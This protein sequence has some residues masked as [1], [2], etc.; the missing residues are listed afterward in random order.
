MTLTAPGV[1]VHVDKRT[2]KVCL[3]TKPGGVNLP[4]WHAEKGL[5]FTHFVRDLRRLMGDY[6]DVQYFR[7]VEAQERHA[8]H[9]HLLVRCRG[10]L[11]AKKEAI[12]RLAIK[13]GFGHS[14]DLRWA[15]P[16]DAGY[17]A[18]YVSVSCD[19]KAEVPWLDKA[20]GE[21]VRPRFR[22]WTATRRWGLTRRKLKEQQVEWV[23]AQASKRSAVE[24]ARQG[25]DGA[26][27]RASSHGQ[28]GYC[29]LDSYTASYPEPGSAPVEGR[30]W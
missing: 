4:V 27:P 25:V 19:K 17:I 30:G 9:D 24:E 12:R 3:C 15:R 7:G 29:P 8:L 23:R 18:K 10:D 6:D 21:L 14:L 1:R 16:G 22:T 26:P 20:S 5:N 11:V 13:H 28:S 2:G